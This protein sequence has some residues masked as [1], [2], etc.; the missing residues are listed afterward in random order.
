MA[1]DASMDIMCD[2]DIHELT[3]AVDQAKRELVIRYDLK[4]LAI[5]IKQNDENI[6]ITAPSDLALN[7]TW[8][9]LLQKVI[10]RQL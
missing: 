4:D 2:F 1:S 10:N 5:E 8:D 7:S 9:I 6:T 3:N